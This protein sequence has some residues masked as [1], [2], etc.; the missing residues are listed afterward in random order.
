[1][2]SITAWHSVAMI[3]CF[4]DISVDRRPM[5]AF[6]QA[7]TQAS[8]YHAALVAV[9]VIV[10]VAVAARSARRNKSPFIPGTSEYKKCPIPIDVLKS[11]DSTLQYCCYRDCYIQCDGVGGGPL[12]YK[13]CRENCLWP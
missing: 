8:V 11:G 10:V 7:F 3:F 9:L 12:C 6:T 4:L 13:M 1:M 5:P 2:R